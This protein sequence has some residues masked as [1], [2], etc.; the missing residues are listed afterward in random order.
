MI[1]SAS[2]RTDIPAF[3]SDW[4]INRVHAGYALVPNPL[5]RQQIRRVDLTPA[6]VD[7]IVFWS[8]N[9]APMLPH[10]SELADFPFYFLFTLNGFGQG[11]E[12]SVPP[13]AETIATFQRLAAK[14][15]PDRVIWRYDPILLAPSLSLNDHLANFAAIA[16]ELDGFTNQCII[17][18]IDH[19]RKID[20]RLEKLGITDLTFNQIRD[21]TRGL[22]EIGRDHHLT[23]K[24]C[25]EDY[26]LSPFG[27]EPAHCIDA[28]LIGQIIGRPFTAARDRNQ[29]P[30]CGCAASVDI[31][32]YNTCPHGCVYCYAT[33]NAA[34]ARRRF[35]AHDQLGE[36]LE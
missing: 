11:L 4:F 16:R 33:T 6:A 35:L 5:N 12:K 27:I 23:L 22:T 30:A 17:S 9:P 7:C 13:R 25:A 1:I 8:K 28:N 24:A 19:Y 21:L 14:L 32:M 36:M 10:L 18:F 26:D 2:R 15:G 3:Y 29:R 31:G 20:K 34:A